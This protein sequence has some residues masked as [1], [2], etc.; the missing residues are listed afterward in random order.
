MPCGGAWPGAPRG[1]SAARGGGRRAGSV[2]GGRRG[3]RSW[4]RVGGSARGAGGRDAA[5]GCCPRSTGAP[6][7]SGLVLDFQQHAGS[8]L[9]GLRTVREGAA[10]GR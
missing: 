6:S 9:R 2:R 10:R 3:R 5:A 8:T 4:R 7:T 1:W